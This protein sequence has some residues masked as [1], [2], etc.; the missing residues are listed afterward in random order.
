MSMLTP[1]GMGGRYRITGNRHPRMRRPRG[2]RRFVLATTASVVTLG[3]V[4]WGTLQLVSVFAGDDGQTVSSRKAGPGCGPVPA[5]QEE[6]QEREELPE[7]SAIT[8]NVYNA[9]TRAGLAQDTADELEKRGFKIGEVGNA[10]P[11]YDK[12]LKAA[13]L[14][15]G[16]PKTEKNGAFTVLGAHLAGAET[17][18]D[19]AREGKAA[20]SLDLI[21]GNGYKTLSKPRDAEKTLAAPAAAPA[22]SATS[23]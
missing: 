21:I 22:P 7:T 16:T 5:K 3:L 18:T 19:A 8:V 4:T 13:G 20:T 6:R 2:R 1:P 14:L 10:P 9:T 15:L 17:K 23:C 12:K 11:R